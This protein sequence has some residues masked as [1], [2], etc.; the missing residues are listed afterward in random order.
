MS[1]RDG[2]LFQIFR[3]VTRPGVLFVLLLA[4]VVGLVVMADAEDNAKCARLL[5]MARS[6]RDSLDAA[7]ACEAIKSATATTIAIGAAAGAV[8]GSAASRR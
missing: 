3:F 6:S 1:D 5:G 8:A 4:L 2:L 7:I